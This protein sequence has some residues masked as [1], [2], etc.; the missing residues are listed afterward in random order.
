MPSSARRFA[1][2]R[3]DSVSEAT[4][5][6]TT[7]PLSTSLSV[8]SSSISKLPFL[9][10]WPSRTWMARTT[11]ISRDCIDCK[12]PNGTNLPCA[13]A[14]I[15]ILPIYAHPKAMTKKAQSVSAIARAAGDAGRSITSMAEGKNAS[16][17]S[18]RFGAWCRAHHRR[19]DHF[20]FG[21]EGEA[22]GASIFI[23]CSI[24]GIALYLFTDIS[25]LQRI[26]PCIS[27]ILCE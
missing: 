3:S 4:N 26:E 20:G 13:T 19:K 22:G 9:T 1:S 2:S 18:P 25:G 16:S 12:P 21:V 27:T 10:S 24:G 11:P 5:S 8:G 7:W 14:T 6:R 17:S 23:C 15:S